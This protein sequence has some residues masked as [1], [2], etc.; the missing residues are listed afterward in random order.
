MWG[1]WEG[2][3]RGRGEKNLL[4]GSKG[5]KVTGDESTRHSDGKI[6]H[7]TLRQLCKAMPCYAKMWLDSEARRANVRYASRK[8]VQAHC[9]EQYPPMQESQSKLMT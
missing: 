7:R 2:T 9:R 6:S 1:T 3:P 8:F 4:E 5:K